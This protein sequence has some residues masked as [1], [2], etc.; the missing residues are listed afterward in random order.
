MKT[1]CFSGSVTRFAGFVLVCATVASL[2]TFSLRQP[3][4]SP[5]RGFLMPFLAFFVIYTLNTESLSGRTTLMTQAANTT[6]IQRGNMFAIVSMWVVMCPWMSP[7][8]LALPVAI[9]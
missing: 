6:H 5:A 4:I 8:A 7:R 9:Q 2:T 3:I 1:Q